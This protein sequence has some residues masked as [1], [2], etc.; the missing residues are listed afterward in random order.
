M[1]FDL[2]PYGAFIWPAYAVSALLLGG[3]TLWAMARWR[4]VKAK[5]ATLEK[6]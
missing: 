5:L 2:S 6:T 3:L 1:N 4:A